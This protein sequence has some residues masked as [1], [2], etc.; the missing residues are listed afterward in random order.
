MNGVGLLAFI[1]IYALG[2]WALARPWSTTRR[3][4]KSM[5]RHS[6]AMAGMNRAARKE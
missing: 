2:V 3:E 4:A 6:D 5:R 1:F